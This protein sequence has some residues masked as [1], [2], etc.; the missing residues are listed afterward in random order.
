MRA[1]EEN[2]NQIKRYLLKKEKYRIHFIHTKRNAKKTCNE[3]YGGLMIKQI[4]KGKTVNIT[5]RLSLLT[6]V[7]CVCLE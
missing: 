1:K 7:H 5:Q 4:G 2:I 3:S 6:M